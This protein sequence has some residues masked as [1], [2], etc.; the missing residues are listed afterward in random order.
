MEYQVLLDVKYLRICRPTLPIYVTFFVGPWYLRE[1]LA[2]CRLQPPVEDLQDSE[3]DLQQRFS[4][5]RAH[6]FF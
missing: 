2:E 1:N 5:N 3:I 4:C 6:N